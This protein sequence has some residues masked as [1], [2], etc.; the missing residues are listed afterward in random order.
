MQGSYLKFFV[1]E[2]TRHHGR[3][4]YEW[5]LEEAK[6]QG[7]PGG[8]VFKA[9]AGYG[10]HGQLHEAHFI[11]LAGELPMEVVFAVSDADAD[12]LLDTLRQ[13]GLDLVYVRMTA[14][15]GRVGG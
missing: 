13:A 12:R 10:R 6:R 2:K 1:Q 7:L 14:E 11:E 9:V 8:S 3:L 15:V 4:L 5:L